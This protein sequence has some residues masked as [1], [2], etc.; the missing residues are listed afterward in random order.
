MINLAKYTKQILLQDFGIEQQQKLMQSKVL[1]VGAGG[2]GCPA[3]L[4]LNAMGIGSLGLIDDD[5]VELS[6]LHRQVLYGVDDIG[7]LKVIVAKEKL[8][9]QNPDTEIIVHPIRLNNQNA[10]SIISMYDVIVDGSDNFE[11]RYMVNDACEILC[12]PLVYASVS[13]YEAQLGVFHLLQN[14][15]STSYRDAFPIPPK[16]NEIPNCNEAGILGV[17][18]G[19]VGSMQAAEVVKIITGIGN[20]LA[21]RILVMNFLQ[22]QFYEIKVFPTSQYK[23]SS[24]EFLIK[25]YSLTC[26][27]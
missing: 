26:A 23:M 18:P 15:I 16:P 6:N 1:V 8:T 3:L 25:D 13:G 24:E 4:Y 5:K 21:N 19:I 7:K 9:S 10:L 27:L 11:T 22:N 12:K 17:Y 14:D 2:L 20:P